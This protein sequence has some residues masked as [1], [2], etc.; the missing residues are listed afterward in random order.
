[1]VEE[2]PSSLTRVK[3]VDVFP[4]EKGGCPQNEW[5][6]KEDRDDCRECEAH[7]TGFVPDRPMGEGVVENVEEAGE[8]GR[9]P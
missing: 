5:K 6:R 9:E 8:E 2:G 3:I 4:L 1:M 7:C